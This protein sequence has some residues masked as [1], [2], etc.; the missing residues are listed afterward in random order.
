MSCRAH[1]VF[2]SLLSELPLSLIPPTPSPRAMFASRRLRVPITHLTEQITSISP[3]GSFRAA[4]L[5]FSGHRTRLE[6]LWSFTSACLSLFVWLLI[7]SA[8]LAALFDMG[9]QFVHSSRQSK[10]SDLVVTFGTYLVVVS[11]ARSMRRNA[12]ELMMGAEGR[13]S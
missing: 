4:P 8:L 2:P 1:S 3:W 5:A 9:Q 12:E 11:P 13:R 6:R 7:V 10:A